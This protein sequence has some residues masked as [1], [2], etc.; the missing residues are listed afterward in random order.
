MRGYLW[1]RSFHAEVAQALPERL[2]QRHKNGAAAH[3]SYGFMQQVD[4]GEAGE[5]RQLPRELC[6]RSWAFRRTFASAGPLRQ[7][8]A[9]AA[10]SAWEK[11]RV[12][13]DTASRMHTSRLSSRLSMEQL[14]GASSASVAADAIF[15]DPSAILTAHP[16]R[17]GKA[18][19]AGN[20][21]EARSHI[22]SA[23][24]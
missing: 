16:R 5:R 8:G 9:S 7:A 3:V 10:T 12:R 14:A 4:A 15:R 24:P 11:P 6:L 23:K 20:A 19:A 13:R 21:D 22:P 1:Q 18:W 17:Q 2:A